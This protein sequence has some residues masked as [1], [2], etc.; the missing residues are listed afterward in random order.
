[1]KILTVDVGSTYT[2]LTAIDS[3]QHAIIG[4]AQSFTTI[5]TDVMTGFENAYRILTE[6]R[7]DNPCANFKHD[8]L[9]VCSSA[10]G[11]LKMVALG[12]VPDLTSKAAR[13]AASNAGAKVVKTYAYEISGDEEKE[14]YDINPD[15]VL[16]CGG[17]DGGNKEVITANAK[18]L[19]NI[20]RNFTT[21]VAGN[22]SATDE[23]KTIFIKA[24][25]SF[26]I[27]ENVMPEFNRLNIEPARD[28]IRNMFIQRI[29]EAKGLNRLQA[30][31]A[32]KIIPTPLAVL[33]ACELLA[34]GT[35]QQEGMGDLLA[36]DIGGATTD[37]YSM[38]SG[39][40]TV[41]STMTKGLPEPWAKRTV[42]GD[43]G[44]RYSLPH[45]FEQIDNAAQPT[46]IQK[47]QI[48]KWVELC[49]NKPDT[50][51][52]PNTEEEL[53]EEY[54]GRTAVALAV[55]RHCG[56]MEDVYTP[57]GLMHTLEGK[58]LMQVPA[59][60][61]IG[62]VVRNSRRP[63][64]ILKGAL[65]D[66]RHAASTRPTK[67]KFYIDQKYIYAAMGLL[68]A[69]DKELALELLKKETKEID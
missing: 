57:F 53:I 46:T 25:K 36:V 28:A 14:I 37:V 42:E 63:K 58:D 4:T 12:L 21:I 54:L 55:E 35:K 69:I 9:I 34:K 62:G 47:E 50:L 13:T 16:L 22:K 39:E 17:T 32:H 8:E 65:Y 48:E 68:T 45:V 66:I 60:I 31:T 19:C 5:E 44:M 52:K 11:G 49:H 64:E 18:R 24:G 33:Q 59:V 30:M 43:L 7:D 15:L 29:I 1:M 20:D 10:A 67:P 6:K 27:T 23:I 38:G 3:E 51:A 2:K 41:D 61:G 56:H 40:P 26:I